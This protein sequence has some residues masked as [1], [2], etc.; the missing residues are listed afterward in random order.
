VLKFIINH[1]LNK[2]KKIKSIINFFRWQLGS[3]ILKKPVIINFVNRSRL[4]VEK[5]MTGATGNIYIGLHE[6]EGMSFV[7]HL[8][9]KDD[10]MLDIGA[11]IG[12]YTILAGAVV[13]AKCF[14]FEPIPDT[15]R[16]LIDNVNINGIYE[17]VKC[18][19]IGLANKNGILKFTSNLDDKNHVVCNTSSIKNIDIID[20]P[21][22]KLD[23]IVSGCDPLLIKIDV[24]GFELQVLKG[25]DE[26]LK[27]KSLLA[28]IIETFGKNNLDKQMSKYGFKPFTYNPFNREISPF[29][30]KKVT[31]NN[32][33]YIKN[34]EK[35]NERIRSSPKFLI[36]GKK[37]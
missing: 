6:F 27:S 22:K 33:I 7:L 35:V 25:A 16:Y 15:F 31:S 11:N 30:S 19:N 10:L 21:V 3:R 8:L 37:I 1:P 32:T 2:D 23:T 14:A 4:I 28:V 18:Y 26:I 13:G 36:N 17:K 24:E 5:G 9:R 12:S 29:D 20:V 34:I